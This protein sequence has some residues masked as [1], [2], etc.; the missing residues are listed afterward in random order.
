MDLATAKALWRAVVPDAA[1]IAYAAEQ[2]NIPAAIVVISP[3]VS[4]TFHNKNA[5]ARLVS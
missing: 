3:T 4:I 5:F 1:A 2:V